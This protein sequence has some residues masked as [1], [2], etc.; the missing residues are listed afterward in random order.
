MNWGKGIILV[1]VAFAAIVFTMVGICMKQDDLHLVTANYYE[2]EIHYQDHIEKA[3]NAAE[4]A[5][6]ALVFDAGQKELQI[7]LESGAKGT[8]WL[9]RPSDAKLDQKLSLDFGK[10]PVRLV[11]LRSLKNGYWKV[12]L[13]WEKDGKAYYEEKQITL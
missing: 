9:F 8:L 4:L 1:F 3:S 6:K 7:R 12:K 13:S 2:E 5:D 11:N 10:D